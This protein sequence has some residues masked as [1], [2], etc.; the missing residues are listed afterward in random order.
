MELMQ[1]YSWPGNVRQ[2]KGVIE[3][4]A[5][6]CEGGAIR[7]KDI[8][9][10]IPETASIHN[11]PARNFVGAYSA[12]IIMNERQWFEKAIIKSNGNRTNA[13]KVLEI[14]RVTFFRRA[15]ELGLVRGRHVT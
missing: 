2:L 5:T 6:R 1:S 4:L 14:S 10:V 13:A 15:K 7:E 12:S 9:T 11:T 3:S 8:Y